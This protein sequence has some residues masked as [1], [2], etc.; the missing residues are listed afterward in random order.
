MINK[1]E[2]CISSVIDE[3]LKFVI[4][5]ENLK[6]SNGFKFVSDI[7]IVLICVPTPLNKHHL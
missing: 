7:Y 3:E 2:N 5:N 4:K 6:A 1:G